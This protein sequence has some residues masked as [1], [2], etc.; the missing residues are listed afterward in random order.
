MSTHIWIY[1]TSTALIIVVFYL[2]YL[3]GSNKMNSEIIKLQEQFID[4]TKKQTR[5]HE[6][7][8]LFTNSLITKSKKSI[9]THNK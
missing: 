5:D 9:K 8:I 6:K 4:I 7:Q 2:G 3:Y 1:I